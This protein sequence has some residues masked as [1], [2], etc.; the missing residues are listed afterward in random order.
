MQ[1]LHIAP[2]LLLAVASPSLALELVDLQ[3]YASVKGLLDLLIIAEPSPI[4]AF[5][6]PSGATPQALAFT[7]CRRV[8][9]GQATCPPSTYPAYNGVRWQVQPGDTVRFRLINRLPNA[10]DVEAAGSEPFLALNPVNM[11]THGL[12]VSPLSDALGNLSDNVFVLI[13]NA[14]NGMPSNTSLQRH[15]NMLGP[16]TVLQNYADYKIA[17]PAA[18]PPGLFWFHAH[19]HGLSLRH[20]AAGLSGVITVGSVKDYVC[21]PG[22]GCDASSLPTR[23]LLLRSTQVVQGQRHDENDPDFCA[24]VPKPSAP[25]RNGFCP[26]LAGGTNYFPVNGQVF[27]QITLNSSQGEIW[28]IT[29]AAGSN[30][31]NLRIVETVSPAGG[32]ARAHRNLVFQIL[33]IDGV[34]VSSGASPTGPHRFTPA[35]CAQ[36]LTNGLCATEV[37]M[38]PSTRVEIH[39]LYRNKAG[40]V[41]V[42]PAHAKIVLQTTHVKTGPGGDNW[43]Q[44]NL[45]RILFAYAKPPLL[46]PKPLLVEPP[47]T[48]PP[49]T[50]SVVVTPGS[51]AASAAPCRSL[52]SGYRRRIYFGVPRQDPDAFALANELVD[53]KGVAVPGSTTSM[54]MFNVSDVPIC[55]ALGGQVQVT[56]T[57]S[58]VNLAS[59][60]HN[61]HIHQTK[62]RVVQ[63]HVDSIPGQVVQQRSVLMDSVPLPF[64]QGAC[65]L[66]VEDWKAGRCQAP[67]TIVEIPFAFAGD[68]VF[69]CHILEH[70]D[71][72]MMTRMRV[73]S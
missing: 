64:A 37:L 62:F 21:P 59:E 8:Q 1:L 7:V 18:H 28:R 11:H 2:L 44:A 17:L 27:P 51:T 13:F 19:V 31:M 23:H 46:D 53:D 3:T 66:D 72:G 22:S 54:S 55:V 49:L 41:A 32:G 48:S 24:P 10:T 34:A 29:N 16:L 67:E 45:A 73:T 38:M 12:L 58:L 39:V 43:P 57:W 33:A 47:P 25:P 56:E 9:A 30:S 69:H 42:A 61:F 50:R 40:V 14:A 36:N 68:F 63:S 60:M 65:D 71:G 52:A 20:L 26:G 35:P 5:R 4:P 70:E 6:Q 15:M